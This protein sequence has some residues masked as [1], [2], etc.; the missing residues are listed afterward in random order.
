MKGG[1]DQ[2]GR[3]DRSP[4]EQCP[5]PPPAQQETRGF[6]ANNY[7]TWTV[8]FISGVIVSVT[9]LAEL[10]LTQPSRFHQFLGCHAYNLI[11]N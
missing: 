10:R 6:I 9:N 3:T 2:Q 8:R 1:P 7:N 5:R 11:A 4:P